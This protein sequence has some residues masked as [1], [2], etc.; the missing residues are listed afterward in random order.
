MRSNLFVACAALG[1]LG[2]GTQA[3]VVPV[4]GQVTL[5]GRPLPHALVTFQP[6]AHDKNPNPGPGS[7]GR[8]D[9]EGRY[10]LRVVGRP[11]SG[12]LTGNHRVSIVA[13]EGEVPGTTDDANPAL[14]RQILPERYN[15]T[16]ELSIRV[17]ANGTDAADFP[18]T[19]QEAPAPEAPKEKADG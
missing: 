2:C 16:T 17:P 7:T 9:A 14:P 12:A 19:S 10:T 11:E 5:D 13:Y 3:K 4:S 15:A 1:L 8:T 6:V 18:L